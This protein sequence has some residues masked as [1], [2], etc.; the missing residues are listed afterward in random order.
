MTIENLVNATLLIGKTIHYRQR[1]GC[2]WKIVL[3]LIKIPGKTYVLLSTS[4]SSITCK[5]SVAKTKALVVD[6][7][8]KEGLLAS[9]VANIETDYVAVSAAIFWTQNSK[10][11]G[12]LYHLSNRTSTAYRISSKIKNIESFLEGNHVVHSSRKPI[13]CD[14]GTVF[15]GVDQQ[16]ANY[17]EAWKNGIIEERLGKEL[18]RRSAHLRHFILEKRGKDWLDITRK[19]M[20]DYAVYYG[21]CS[22]NK[23]ISCW[24]IIR[25][26]IIDEF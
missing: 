6:Q 26:K 1:N 12:L 21:I 5:R 3:Q 14:S 13:V 20:T 24:E 10:A 8:P 22:F 9:K 16:L 15:L 11:M 7:F 2:C 17:A 23:G 18:N 19:L 4:N 25:F